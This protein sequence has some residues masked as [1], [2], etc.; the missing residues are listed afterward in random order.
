MEYSRDSSF[1]MGIAHLVRIDALL[2]DLAQNSADEDY[3]AWHKSLT[4]I[5]REVFFLFSDP[6]MEE[7]NKLDNKCVESINKFFVD[8]TMKD[9]QDAYNALVN[10]ELFLKKQLAQRK[11]LMAFGRDVRSAIADIN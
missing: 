11:M 7:N 6:E 8:K 2:Y 5:S 10:Y 1:N 3:T 4:L 9:K